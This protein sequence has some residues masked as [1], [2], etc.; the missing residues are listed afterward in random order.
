MTDLFRMEA[1]PELFA[2]EI[3]LENLPGAESVA[4]LHPMGYQSEL[5]LR[6]DSWPDAKTW[7]K[8]FDFFKFSEPAAFARYVKHLSLQTGVVN[9]T[10]LEELLKGAGS[11]AGKLDEWLFL[12]GAPESICALHHQKT[13]PLKILRLAPAGEQADLFCA[14]LCQDAFKANIAREIF[15]M[16][17]DFLPDDQKR[18]FDELQK[19]Y[20]SPDFVH[21]VDPNRFG[22]KARELFYRMRYPFL[23]RKHDEIDALIDEIQSTI[24]VKLFYESDLER[25]ELKLEAKLKS[26]QEAGQLC[27]HL[28]SK[29]FVQ[30]LEKILQTMTQI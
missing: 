11:S 28:Q 22:K 27:V 15:S 23:S 29:N 3:Y 20:Q 18:A 12:A 4:A 5:V 17:V 8:I 19:L 2:P 10:M 1:T 7:K 24:P 13:I 14:F 9:A 6:F 16:W 21:P 30:G 26:A 25:A